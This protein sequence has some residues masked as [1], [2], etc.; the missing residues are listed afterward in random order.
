[1]GDESNSIAINWDK[2]FSAVRKIDIATCEACAVSQGIGVREAEAFKS[3]STYVFS[4]L[5]QHSH[6]LIAALPISRWSK[7]EYQN[8]DLSH[9]A[10]HVRAILEGEVFFLYISNTPASNEEFSAK[11]NTLHLN[12]CVKRI[13]FMKSFE[14]H[15]S[16]AGFEKQK[17]EITQRFENND[18]FNALSSSVKKKILSGKSTM[19]YNRDDILREN[20]IDVSQFKVNFDFL[21]HY[22][23]ILPMSFY[24]MESNGRGTGSLNE[25]DF[26]Y[27]CLYVD[28]A[29]EAIV[30][31]T[32]R[33]IELFP[34]AARH[35]KGLKSKF[36]FGPKPRN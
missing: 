30:H 34:D 36:S 22:T 4:R 9:I 1:M 28:I 15:E 7:R 5:C 27:I 35:R 12:D 16:V 19:I 8:W 31:C 6:A 29:A 18:F 32:D 3:W 13:E 2:Y 21:S 17:E 14:D 20:G 33:L 24:R 10:P 26:N 23:H 25:A 11:I